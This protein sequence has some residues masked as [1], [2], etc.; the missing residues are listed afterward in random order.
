MELA[1]LTEPLLHS[2]EQLTW[3]QRLDRELAN[4][5]AAFKWFAES[6][7][8]LFTKSAL[9]LCGAL[10]WYWH[11]RGDHAESR[12]LVGSLL[13]SAAAQRPSLGRARALATYGVMTWGMGDPAGALALHDESLVLTRQFR[14]AHAV[15]EV[16]MHAAVAASFMATFRGPRPRAVRHWIW[17][18]RPAQSTSRACR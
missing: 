10:W 12:E 9:R 11:V 1:E 16:L 8:E 5:R 2:R 15:V 4:F 3:F 18:E 13:A 17:R 14:D 6:Q 7:D